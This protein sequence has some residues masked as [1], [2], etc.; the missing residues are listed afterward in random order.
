MQLLDGSG[1]PISGKTA[2]TDANG[3]YSFTGL[4]PG[5][6]EVKVGAPAGG[7]LPPLPHAV[8]AG[9]DEQC[10]GAA[11]K[12]ANLGSSFMDGADDVVA[13]SA[14]DIFTAM[15]TCCGTCSNRTVPNVCKAWDVWIAGDASYLCQVRRSK[16][17]RGRG[18]ATA[19][20]SAWP[21][22][23]LSSRGNLGAAAHQLA[24]SWQGG[25]LCARAQ[26]QSRHGELCLLA[27]TWAAM[28]A[29][30]LP[31]SR[32][33]RACCI[34][35]PVWQRGQHDAATVCHAASRNAACFPLGGALLAVPPIHPR[36]FF[37]ACGTDKRSAMPCTA[38]SGPTPPTQ[39]L[40]NAHLPC[41]HCPTA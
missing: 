3:A 14:P 18:T 11:G 28:S 32:K 23:V 2:V 13:V 36:T 40:A 21:W 33:I 5:S 4:A 34:S 20:R 38:P 31:H 35:A 41:M 27:G 16:M 7:N 15:E 1:T 22:W 39:T 8:V 25:T 10:V 24:A 9:Q 26:S 19:G 17:L 12:F 6:Y 29:S 30:W 37:A